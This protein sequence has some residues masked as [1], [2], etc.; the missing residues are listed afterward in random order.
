MGGED[1]MEGRLADLALVT[2][3]QSP[4]GSLV[5]SEARG[6]PLLNGP[7]EFGPHHPS[8]VQ[9]TTDGRKQADEGDLLFCV[10]GSTTGR[11][12]WADRKYAIG[13]GVAAIRHVA[14]KDYQPYLRGVI[15]AKLQDLLATVTGSTFPN[16]SR[17][18]LLSL[19]VTV[20]PL[21]E[22]KRI[23]HILGTLD[24]KIELNRRMCQTLEEM[25]RALFKSW[26]V[27]FDPV[28]AKAEGRQPAGM[29][30]AT[31]A[32]FPDS[33]VDSELGMIPRG[34][35]TGSFGS[36]T[37][38][39][40]ERAGVREV[41]VL[42]AIAS[43]SLV[44]S[45][46]HFT[47]QVYSKETTKYLLV[48]QWDYAYNP[49]RVNIGSIG[50]LEE[51]LVGG[52][53][54]VYVVVRPRDAFRWFLHFSLL[55]PHTK[56][57]IQTLASGSVRQSL[58]YYDFASIPSVLPTEPVLHLFDRKWASL[59]DAIRASEAESDTLAELRD[60]LL[61]QLLNGAG[62][63]DRVDAVGGQAGRAD[64]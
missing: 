50:M 26:F 55:Q 8:P 29:D 52:V 25:A 47:K 3:G 22:Q 39:R 58:S 61:P 45:D 11:M 28:R 4:P 14:G 36:F 7:T 41:V 40:T 32:L 20:P 23:A 62:D 48:E 16:L 60:A 10:R 43:G 13:R 27:D 57:W 49:S 35:E 31:A 54:P 24:D 38:Q 34:W 9:F 64:A 44:R 59:R 2:M 12:N 46:D 17:D 19:P 15:E 42:S 63:V 1:T 5:T 33:F 21:S 18:Q 37:S 53:S 51:D 56:R 30:A 6:L